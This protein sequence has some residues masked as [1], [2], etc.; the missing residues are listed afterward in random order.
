M[1]EAVW[2]SCEDPEPMLDFLNGRASVR[3]FRLYSCADCRRVWS[4]FEEFERQA[5][6]VAEQYADGNASDA[7]LVAINQVRGMSGS[8]AY[9][10]TV[11]NAASGA[12]GTAY[13]IAG[14]VGHTV[15]VEEIESVTKAE[16]RL[17]GGVVRDIF[18]N[19][20]RPVAFDPAWFTPTVLALANGIYTDRAF[21]RMPI[22]ADALEEAG[23]D[24]PDILLHCRE[25]GEHVR[26]CWVVDLVLGKE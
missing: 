15:D 22:L 7:E 5:I 18:G 19:P 1:T 21:D 17:Q 4:W 3:K 24:N 11:T 12:F 25:P 8:I 2:L 6:E 13:S 14:T 16:K 20:F 26:G 23:C 9:Q 10:T